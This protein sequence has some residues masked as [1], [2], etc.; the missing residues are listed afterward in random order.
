MFNFISQ[1]IPQKEDADELFVCLCSSA[2]EV[3][4]FFLLPLLQVFGNRN[5]AFSAPRDFE[6]SCKSSLDQCQFTFSSN[7]ALLN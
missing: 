6:E 4:D 1:I 5:C 7:H 3:L 2:A